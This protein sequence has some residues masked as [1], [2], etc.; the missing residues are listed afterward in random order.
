MNN[1]L[2]DILFIMYRLFFMLVSVYVI[3]RMT[4]LGD[5]DRYAEAVLGTSIMNLI[6]YRSD[7]ALTDT[8][9][10]LLRTLFLGRML[11]VNIFLNLISSF[12]MIRLIRKINYKFIFL[13][14]FLS[15]SFNIWSSFASK[16]IIIVTAMAIMF[17]EIISY[18][19][20]EKVHYII[21]FFCAFIIMFYKLQLILPVIQ[22]ILSI[23][24]LHQYSRESGIVIIPLILVVNIL[25]IFIMRD[26][27]D[28][29]VR[30]I[31]VHFS[32]SSRS[33]RDSAFLM[34]N[35]GFFIKLPY[36]MFI[37]FF[38]PTVSEM[39]TSI[40][41]AFTAVES[42]LIIGTLGYLILIRNKKFIKPDYIHVMV[43]L[44]LLLLLMFFQTPWGILNPGSAIRYRA[45]YYIYILIIIYLYREDFF[46]LKY[47]DEN[48]KSEET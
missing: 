7:T 11:F 44:N 13:V 48:D 15:P 23:W 43:L 2:V 46:I 25:G 29:L 12:A 18:L 22:L 19:K 21:G 26:Y 9:V 14:L 1:K 5:Y 16:E 17:T 40:L 10:S 8:I 36:G 27:V 42:T 3:S 45:D 6:Q 4:T 31:I 28:D 20:D 30:S 33:T 41:H 47:G 24:L 34:Q 38:G 37:T 32:A 39:S 35:Y